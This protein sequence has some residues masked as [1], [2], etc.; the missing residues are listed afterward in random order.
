MKRGAGPAVE[1][2][3]TGAEGTRV[4]RRV[5]AAGRG[6]REGGPTSFLRSSS[7]SLTN[8]AF[9]HACRAAWRGAVYGGAR[10]RTAW[11][12]CALAWCAY[13][14]PCLV[15][16][17][18]RP[19]RVE[20]CHLTRRDT[21]ALVSQRCV[22]HARRNGAWCMVQRPCRRGVR[23][24]ASSPS[25]VGPRVHSSPDLRSSGA[26][27]CARG[28]AP[29]SFSQKAC[30]MGRG[31]R[32]G[33]ERRWGGEGGGRAAR[34]RRRAGGR[35]VG[36]GCLEVALGDVSVGHALEVAGRRVAQP[37]A[38]APLHPPGSGTKDATTSTAP[39]SSA[40]QRSAQRMAWHA[41]HGM[42]PAACASSCAPSSTRAA[43]PPS[44]R[45]AAPAARE[46]AMASAVPR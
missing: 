3:L 33:R 18:G 12:R 21:V 1:G 38:S 9:S 23:T 45:P 17:F 14:M 24:S 2:L 37:V 22:M 10:H 32:T 13:A 34:G 7:S 27:R 26:A 46:H 36:G 19:G 5:A 16:R 28:I 6:W 42:G 11:R 8:S 41:W 4:S 29:Y 39:S 31:V 25:L 35:A 30:R 44:R 43:P 40:A 15:R 20:L